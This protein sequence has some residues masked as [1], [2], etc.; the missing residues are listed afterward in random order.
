[1]IPFETLRSAPYSLEWAS[2]IQVKVQAI[3]LVGESEFSAVGTGAE[4]LNT[5]DAPQ[6]FMNNIGLHHKTQ[7]GVTWY[8]G[9]EPGGRPILD[10]RLW[11]AVGL[12]SDYVI[13][14]DTLTV[15]YYTMTTIEGQWYKFKVQSRNSQGYGEFAPELQIRSAQVPDIPGT[16]VT[17]WLPDD[18]TVTWT[19]PNHNGDEITHYI[20]KIR[21]SNIGVYAQELTYCNGAD[22]TVRD[23]QTCSIPVG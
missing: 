1:V 23:T 13:L 21:T 7:I 18:V 22:A 15:Q 14:D 19:A 11:Y 17:S 10:Y 5:P 16:P 6:S 20:V 4:I 3:T 8:D 2:F 12:D 9:P